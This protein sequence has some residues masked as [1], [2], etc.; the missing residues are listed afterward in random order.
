VF[1]DRLLLV[2]SFHKTMSD[3]QRDP[4]E[5]TNNAALLEFADNFAIPPVPRARMRHKSGIR[6]S[7]FFP[8]Y[9]PYVQM[10][11]LH[12]HYLKPNV[13]S[14]PE[15][16]YWQIRNS[17]GLLDVT[18]EEVIAIEGPDALALMNSLVPRDLEKLADGH[19][20][21]CVMCYDHGG[22][23]EDAV[24][25]RFDEQKLWWVGGPG[26]SEQWIYGHSLGREV[27]V[28]GHNDSLHVASLQGPESRDILT[29][30]ADFDA[31]TLPVFGVG[32]GSIAGVEATVTRTGYTAE[33][34]YDIYVDVRTGERLFA[35]LFDAVSARGGGLCGSAALNLRRMDAAILNFTEDFDWQHTPYDVGLGW[36]VDAEKSADFTGR[37]A[38]EARAGQEP[39]QK[40]V[41][42][43][44]D[45][46]VPL[47]PGTRLSLNGEEVGEITSATRSPALEQKIALGWVAS[48]AARVGTVL[49]VLL[50]DVSAAAVV[51][52]KPFLDP[53]RKLMRA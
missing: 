47:D 50:D 12:N 35:A 32:E 33:L 23:V 21:Y 45:D 20:L 2:R 1:E 53:K 52:K 41:G 6:R 24:L 37:T 19:A 27:T 51:V 34:G 40:L 22:I 42:L 25:V 4:R 38:L 3:N 13:F 14:T 17:A 11:K 16:E 9:A 15:T 18:G 29:E 28:T 26:Y 39:A 10:L 8:A 48:K 44:L 49:E 5:V 36:M 31:E 7:C 46:E 43:R 30:L